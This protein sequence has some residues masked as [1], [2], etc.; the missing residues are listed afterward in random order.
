LLD[1]AQGCAGD[2]ESEED[3]GAGA[4][5]GDALLAVVLESAEHGDGKNGG[6]GGQSPQKPGG[7][8]FARSGTA[9]GD[10]SHYAVGKSGGRGTG[11]E[12]MV[13]VALEIVGKAV[14]TGIEWISHGC[15]P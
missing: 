1:F 4:L 13:Q 3:L 5:A 8:R 12:L 9:L 2:V 14:E 10:A 6:D 7:A 15:T 11:A